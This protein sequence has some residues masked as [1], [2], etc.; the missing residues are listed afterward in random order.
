MFIEL[1]RDWEQPEEMEDPTVAVEEPLLFDCAQ[2]SLR[3]VGLLG[4]QAGQ[5]LLPHQDFT[6][7]AIPSDLKGREQTGGFDLQEAC[8]AR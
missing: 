7:L 8:V 3:G 4:D 2:A 6:S 5:Q 1:G